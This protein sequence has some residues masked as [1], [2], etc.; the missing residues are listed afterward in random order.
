MIE[1]TRMK[2]GNRK[3]TRTFS[4]SWYDNF[5]WI[6]LCV[7]RKR[8]F[9]YHCL[10]CYLK[11]ILTLTGKK[12]DSAF[13]IEGFCNWK[14][15]TERLERHAKSEC[16]KEAVLKFNSVRAASI[17]EQL[18]T[19]LQRD[20]AEHRNMLLKQLHGLRYLLRQGLPIRGHRENEGNLMQLLQMQSRDCPMLL[21]WIQ[22]GHY[23]S[24][25]TVNEMIGLM[26]NTLLRKLLTDIRAA[27]M[28]SVMADE[29]RDIS[30]DEQMSIVIR[31]V[32]TKYDVP[33]TT[34]CTLTS[35]LKDVLIRCVLPLE[36]CRGQAYDGAS[37][38]MGS[39]TGVAKQVQSEY[40]AAIK[41]HCLAH[42][43]NL[44]LQD[45]AK[46]CKPIRSAL[47]NVMEITQL[48][49]YSPKCTRVF[50]LCKQELS[51]GGVGLRPL[52]PTR[53]TVRT[54]AIE[55]VLK[56]YAALLKAFQTIA[57]TSYDDYGRRANGLYAQLEKF[58]TFFGLKLSFL[59]FS[60]T[61][62]T[63]TNL[64]GKNTSVQEALSC[65]EVAKNYLS[66]LRSD[67]SF[68][69]FYSS[70]VTEAEQYTGSPVLPRY[71]VPPKKIDQGAAPV[72]FK[73]PKDFYR[74]LYFEALDLVHQ[75]ITMRFGQ[76]SMSIPKELESLL[77]SAANAQ[78]LIQVNVPSS[79][80]SL[81]SMDVN[82]ERAK[83]QLMMLPDLVKA[84]KES[85]SLTKL[86]VTSVRTIANVLNDVPMSKDTFREIDTL[87]RLFF[88]IPITTCTAERS[89]SS[90]RRIKT[91]LRSTMTEQRLNNVL[92]LNAYKEETDQLDIQEIASMFI[93]VNDRRRAFFGHF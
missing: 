75:Q 48:V 46:K 2:V 69:R 71:R 1:S 89:F 6:H 88:T 17:V 21:Q 31:W 8:I 85:Q 9:C 52:Y 43:L 84:Y 22:N 41:V 73:S 12:Y 76:E 61:E 18:S 35:V 68:D 65:A 51:I 74:S 16:H 23:L 15:A 57:E 66:R 49:R 32:D 77:I 28:F 20:Q 38:M 63:S 58:D 33:D 54:Q 44:C 70:V 24:H 34:A 45:A 56:N 26:G 11:G 55:A 29:T 90:L 7:T 47:D 92:I 60:G 13:I 14:K 80:I 3:E 36:N 53:W 19:Q 39:I 67:E 27:K 62:Q 87:V 5:K 37:N 81:Y 91:Y 42:C 78:S 64:Q 83:I 30:N 82:F 86:E 40:P 93:A 50:Q 79:L 25:D 59:L 4:T 72:Q 10:D